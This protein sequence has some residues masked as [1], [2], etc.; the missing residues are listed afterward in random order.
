MKQ[1]DFPW[2]I[3]R[4]IVGGTSA[5]D[6]PSLQL[7][8][9][10]EAELFLASYGFDWNIPH[11][12]NE[13][14]SM[15]REALSILEELLEDEP[16]LHIPD[17]IRDNKDVRRLLL[18]ASM[19]PGSE[20]TGIQQRWACSL[21]RLMHT[22]A[23]ARTYFNNRFGQQ[24]RHQILSR[25]EPHLHGTAGVDLRLGGGPGAIA[26]ANFEIKHTK[27]LRSVVMK[28]LH[29]AENVAS[30]IFDR[31]GVRFVTH[32]RFDILRTVH[33][34]RSRSV[35]MFANVKPSRSRNTVLDLDWIRL[36]MDRL[37]AAIERGEID[38]E[39]RHELLRELARQCPQPAL[40]HPVDTTLQNPFSASS[41][42][43]VQFTCRQ[44]IRVQDPQDLDNAQLLA[45]A[46]SRHGPE[47]PIVQALR[48]RVADAQEITFFFPFEVQI[49]DH[50]SFQ[51]TRSGRASHDEY[52]AR[53]HEVV[54]RR[55]LGPLLPNRRFKAESQ[56]R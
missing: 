19:E 13:I 6:V 20:G 41:Y 15:R 43:S 14:D 50:D 17:S 21:L 3:L 51:A 44:L 25:F 22:L 46:E 55:V 42:R 27:P 38:P 39:R 49:L 54:K 48:S 56:S 31:I 52:K 37:D 16:S 47:D 4:S 26:L 2:R 45:R 8:T 34:L 32:E 23:H 53:Q 10:E 9:F 29:K 7:Q 40:P 28:L 1:V 33:Y 12:H 35:I 11:Q 18:W 24:I 5:I 36:E 30:D